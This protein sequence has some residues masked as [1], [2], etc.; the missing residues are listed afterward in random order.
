MPPR[1]RGYALALDAVGLRSVRDMTFSHQ[2]RATDSRFAGAAPDSESLRRLVRSGLGWKLSSQISGQGFR[3]LVAILLAHLLTPHE[4]GIA[5]MAVVFLGIPQIFVDFSLGAALVQREKL[6]AQDISTVFWT[7]LVAGMAVTGACVAASPA[8][9][10]FFSTP[11]V[12]PMFAFAGLSFTI[13]GFGVVQYALLTR[14]MD[15][16]SLEIREIVATLAGGVA[17]VAIAF[18]GF[19][20]WAIVGQ[21]VCT[22]AI[23]TALI[24]KLTPWRPSLCFSRESLRSLGSF[25]LKMF[26]ARLLSYLTTN[27]DNVLVGRFLGS[28]ALGTYAIGYNVVFSPFTRMVRPLQQV[29]FP[30][31]S[32]LQKEPDRL[33]NAWLRGEALIAAVVV[34]ALLGIAAI[35]PDFVTVILGARWNAAV[36]LVQLLGLAGAM[37]V[38]Q[39]INWQVLQAFGEAGKLLRISAFSSTLSVASF[40]VGLHWGIVGVAAG[41]AVSRMPVLW[42]FNRRTSRELGVSTW[43][44]ARG[45]APVLSASI[46]MA[47]TVFTARLALVDIGLAAS[48]RLVLLIALGFSVYMALLYVG[49]RELLADARHLLFRGTGRMTDAT[50]SETLAAS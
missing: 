21:L 37:Q 8:V 40:A 42:V 46:V 30:A 33:A 24:W 41:Y 18:A 13:S 16:R 44:W 28:V 14:A 12:G 3:F 34:P 23:S 22:Y 2:D 6:T 26:S 27:A 5:A 29:L 1:D 10:A 45:L 47:T 9:A 7:T 11:S 4:Y 25:G 20:P 31:F 48:L 17:A 36:P 38:L 49:S 50:Q 43:A 15:F 19:G 32:R 35:A 39:S